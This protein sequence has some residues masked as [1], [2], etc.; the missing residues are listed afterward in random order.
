MQE[1]GKEAPYG[2]LNVAPRAVEK[3]QIARHTQKNIQITKNP[4]IAK[5]ERL[6]TGTHHQEPANEHPSGPQVHG[7]VIH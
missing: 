1:A 4:Q 7:P 6:S 2:M 3:G 5:D